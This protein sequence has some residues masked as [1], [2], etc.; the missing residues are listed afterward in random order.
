MPRDHSLRKYRDAEELHGMT[1]PKQHSYRK[2]CAAVAVNRRKRDEEAHLEPDIF[3]ERC[4]EIVD[5]SENFHRAPIRKQG[6]TPSNGEFCLKH[7]EALRAKTKIRE[8]REPLTIDA[9]I[10]P[11]IIVIAVKRHIVGSISNAQVGKDTASCG[12][13]RKDLRADPRPDL[14]SIV[15]RDLN[16]GS[17]IAHLLER[18]FAEDIQAAN[19]LD[20]RLPVPYVGIKLKVLRTHVEKREAHI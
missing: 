12:Y 13:F 8:L 4:D 18:P 14:V 15:A 2:P 5:V 6:K 20:A 16:A 7:L 10:L 11:L 1:G 19:D 9:V 3:Q 17:V